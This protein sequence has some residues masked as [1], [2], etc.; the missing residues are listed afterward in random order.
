MVHRFGPRPLWTVQPS[1]GR[2]YK[3]AKLLKPIY[4]APAEE[5]ALERFAEFAEARARKYPAIVRL[6]EHHQRDRVRERQDPA[7]G[8]GT[9][10]LPERPP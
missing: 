5:P 1:Q 2:G 7:G 3:I 8:Q 4:T 6:G 9:R 10:A